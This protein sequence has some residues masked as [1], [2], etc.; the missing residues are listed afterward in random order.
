M[1]RKLIFAITC[2]LLLTACA[3]SSTAN[4]TPISTPTNTA[5]DTLTPE[6]VLAQM[7]A[8]EGI[9]L[10]QGP[11][12][13]Q[14]I[15]PTE[16]SFSPS[17]AR[18]WNAQID[19][20]VTGSRCSCDWKFYL[21]EYDQE[22]LYQQM[23]DRQC[24]PSNDPAVPEEAR[25]CGFTSTFIQNRGDLRV[26]VDVTVTNRDGQTPQAADIEQTYRVQ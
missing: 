4:P 1:I 5:Q 3:Q 9:G 16:A 18:F 7:D 10:E 6:E 23:D 20:L 22:T 25:V 14:I 19:G 8:A 17:Q 11:I 12:N 2:S 24:T 21:N 15:S 13:V 26:T